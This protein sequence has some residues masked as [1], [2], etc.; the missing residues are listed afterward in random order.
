MIAQ[1]V[2]PRD[3]TAGQRLRE[4]VEMVREVS[5]ARDA[6]DMLERYR[7]RSHFVVHG[8]AML[9]LSRRGLNGS[10]VRITRATLWPE[11]I[12]PWEEPHRL[13]IVDSG[14]LPQLAIAGRPLKVD[15][16]EL[17]PDDP[18]APYADGMRSLAAAPIFDRGEPTYMVI[19]LRREPSSFTL[20]EL[21][22][23]VLTT[24]LIGRATGNLVLAT[25]LERARETL[26]R[27]LRAVGEV[28][29]ELL[30]R[31]MP[32]IPGVR[33]AAHYETSTRAGGD[34]YNAF[35][36]GDG[37]W[38]FIIADVSGHGAAAA[39]MMAVVHALLQ[40][41]LSGCKNA[42]FSPSAVLSYLND[43]LLRSIA[44]GQFVTAF[45]AIY[46]PATRELRYASAGHNPPRWLRAADQAIIPLMDSDGMPL[47]ITTPFSASE[48]SVR[49]APGDRILLYTD[50]ITETFDAQR[51]MFGTEGLDASLTC[52]RR[53]AEGLISSVFDSLNRFANGAPP[54]DDRTLVA[55]AFE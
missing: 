11:V 47:S 51:R 13:P 38:G 9:S 41:P 52:C 15:E 19:L 54:A 8:D 34:Y 24:N 17:P 33:L 1:S 43:E 36:L 39:V 5:L 45:L 16:L 49:M 14:M 35:P 30:P 18:F 50:G 4:Y 46:D 23:L 32:E 25:E 48:I 2:V 40:A 21:A 7:A 29:R 28:Q 22:T 12:N 44:T 55:L 6:H 53:T 31:R 42:N 3:I 10:A 37:R 26:D 27:E 20:D